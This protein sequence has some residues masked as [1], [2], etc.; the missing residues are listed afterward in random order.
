MDNLPQWVTPRLTYLS[1]SGTDVLN[2]DPGANGIDL[3]SA[4]YAS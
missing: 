2:A 4:N 1:S 3:G